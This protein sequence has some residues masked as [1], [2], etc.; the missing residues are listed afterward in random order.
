[1]KET[2]KLGLILLIVAAVAGGVLA[3]TNSITAP[4]IAAQE[5]EGA[6][7]A[8]MEIF[9]DA[10]ADDFVAIDEGLLSEIASSHE[11]VVEVYEVMEGDTVTGYVFNTSSAG[12][13]GP[14]TTIS[15]FNLDGTVQGIRV[16]ENSETPNLGTVVVEDPAFRE[17]FEGNSTAEPLVSV[18]AP[19]AENEV[20]L[21]SGATVSTNGVVTGVNAAREAFE[22]NFN[23]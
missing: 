1:M 2:L 4:I 13:G 3:F 22:E 10:E 15:G 21:M 17:S 23:N 9:P 18:G 6:F 8:F 5:M 14:I 11:N 7:G 19:A 12:Y 20:L 16:T